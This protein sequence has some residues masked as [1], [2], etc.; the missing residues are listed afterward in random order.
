MRKEKSVEQLAEEL[1]CFGENVLA[2]DSPFITHANMLRQ[3]QAEIEAL[4]KE[5]QELIWKCAD[6]LLIHLKEQSRRYENL[7]S[8]IHKQI[9]DS[10]AI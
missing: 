8:S 3:Q 10:G 9:E 5:N 6:E 2:G 4:K 7:F 1:E